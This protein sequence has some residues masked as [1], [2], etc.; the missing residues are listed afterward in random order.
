M[1]FRLLAVL[2]AVS[3]IPA[4]EAIPY[5]L[6]IGDFLNHAIVIRE[7]DGTISWSQPTPGTV[8]DG[9][10]LANGNILYCENGGGKGTIKEVTRDH[11]VVF[12]HDIPG[13]CQSVQRL[14]D[15]KTLASDPGSKRLIE[16]DAKGEIAKTVTLNS[17]GKGTHLIT[18]IA[19]KQSD[20]GYL[21]GQ[22][23]DQA[24]V[25][26]KADGTEERRIPMK[27]QAH[28]ARRLANG[29]LLIATGN[30]KSVVEIDPA[31]ATVWTFATTDFPAGT[32]PEWTVDAQRLDNGNTQ[33]INWL[34]HGKHG[35]GISLLEVT[36]DKQVVW[37]LGES[38]TVFFAQILAEKP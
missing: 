8:F 17:G 34:G 21:V 37:T 5:R 14:A 30:G 13:E 2:V 20:G 35:K 16:I 22:V 19:R 31:G 3:C 18:R 32:N 1:L 29:N 7:R 28:I 23:A 10:A 12:S 33:I 9:E 4:G 6:L 36:P 15:G 26:Y 38:R 25:G 27:S 24:I 11:Q